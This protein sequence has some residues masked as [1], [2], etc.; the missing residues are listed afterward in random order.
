MKLQGIFLPVATPFDH[1]GEL[2]PVK[3]QHNIGKWNRTSLAGYVVCAEAGEG[4]FLSSEEKIRMWEWVAEY[5]APEKLL[6]A[7]TGM[8]GVHE[9]VA[10]TNRAESLGY[11]AALVRAPQ[12]AEAIYFQAVAD[13]A[14]IP[15]IADGATGLQHPNILAT[16]GDRTLAGS[17]ETVA[18]D[19]AAGATAAILSFAN[20]APYAAISIW[21]AHR[22][23]ETDAALDWQ[24]R[25]APAVELVTTRYG[26]PGLKY[27][28]DLN[29][30]Y[31]GPPR[32]PFT[33]ITPDAKKEIERAFEGIKG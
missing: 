6:I 25:I 8:P 4:P 14:K 21:E 2:Y 33:V 26:V 18:Q 23:R 3:V 7:A 22:T 24:K 27:A 10:L 31:G 5:S 11:K 19:F 32:L 30:Y 15:I 13:Q 17:A 29:G 1:H 16:V 28:M 20:A 9:T 12:Q